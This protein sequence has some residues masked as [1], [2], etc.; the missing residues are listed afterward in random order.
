MRVIYYNYFTIR[1][2]SLNSNQCQ[3]A[4]VLQVLTYESTLRP[5]KNIIIAR[6]R[7][8]FIFGVVLI[9][10]RTYTHVVHKMQQ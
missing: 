4:S 7:D 2:P 3:I 8:Y 9:F 10:F 6:S 1:T 5:L